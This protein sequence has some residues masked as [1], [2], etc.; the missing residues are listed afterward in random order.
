MSYI[1]KVTRV[2]SPKDL[3]IVSCTHRRSAS[4]G[5]AG[6]Q[7]WNRRNTSRGSIR[8]DSALLEEPYP[9]SST[10]SLGRPAI[11]A[12][13]VPEVIHNIREAREEYGEILERIKAP[14][15]AQQQSQE[16]SNSQ[17]PHGRLQPD[18]IEAEIK[19]REDAFFK[20]SHA[21]A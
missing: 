14:S 15:T 16:R 8:P 19:S 21:C 13:K 6:E 5:D 1:V 12:P 17:E 4:A 3:H 20:V 2:L 10:A 9:S 18:S 7:D 11:M